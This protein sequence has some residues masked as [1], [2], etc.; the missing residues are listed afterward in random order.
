MPLCAQ[1]L[2]AQPIP[3]SPESPSG[4]HGYHTGTPPP[5]KITRDSEITNDERVVVEGEIHQ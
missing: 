1:W 4:D 5:T 2:M 3:V